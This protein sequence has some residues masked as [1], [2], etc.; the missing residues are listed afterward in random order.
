[1]ISGK[2]KTGNEKITNLKSSGG[3]MYSMVIIANNT[4]L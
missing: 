4:V 2:G 3:L 1:M